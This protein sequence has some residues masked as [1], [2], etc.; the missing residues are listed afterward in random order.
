VGV[1]K[2]FWREKCLLEKSQSSSINLVSAVKKTKQDTT[3]GYQGKNVGDKKQKY[4]KRLR[5]GYCLSMFLVWGGIG[6]VLAGYWLCIVRYWM[7]IGSVVLLTWSVMMSSTS[8]LS[9]LSDELAGFIEGL[10]LLRAQSAIS[11]VVMVNLYPCA[12][13][14]FEKNV[15]EIVLVEL[16]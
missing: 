7:C 8:M 15:E 2:K 13:F 5:P 11:D 9:T 1:K 3:A 4:Q 6:C 10:P 14:Y 16:K 12:K